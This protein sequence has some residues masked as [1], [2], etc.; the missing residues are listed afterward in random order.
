MPLNSDTTAIVI[1]DHGSKRQ[2]ANEQLDALVALYK[3]TTGTAIIEPAHM[4]LASPTIA[5]A[6]T[7]CV[8]QG[9]T[10]IVVHPYFLAPGRHSIEDIPRMVEEAMAN[11]DGISYR[12]TQPLGIDER[13]CSLIEQRVA[14]AMDRSSLG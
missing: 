1:V 8:R 3:Q 9:A 2:A 12:V 6:I 11:H 14:E 5:D 4:E 7:A 13:L 10:N